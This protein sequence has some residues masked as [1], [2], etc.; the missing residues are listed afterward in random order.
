MAPVSPGSATALDSAENC[1]N[2]KNDKTEFPTEA[3]WLDKISLLDEISTIIS[4]IF[5]Q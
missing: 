5:L 1:E 3:Q 2:V 4:R